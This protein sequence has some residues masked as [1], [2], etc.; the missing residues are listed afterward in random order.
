MSTSAAEV[1]KKSRKI[2][3]SKSAGLKVRTGNYESVEVS[4]AISMDIEFD[5]S[6]ELKKKD[7]ALTSL[8]VSLLKKSADDVMAGTGRWRI[9]GSQAVELWG[10]TDKGPRVKE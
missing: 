8:L 5:S 9:V 10:D 7:E 2:T 1:P 6:D 3:I 4:E